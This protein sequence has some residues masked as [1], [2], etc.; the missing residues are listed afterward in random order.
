MNPS[1]WEE[2]HPSLRPGSK[3]FWTLFLVPQAETLTIENEKSSDGM[4][5]LEL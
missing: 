2:P 5:Q 4:L 1:F 3:E